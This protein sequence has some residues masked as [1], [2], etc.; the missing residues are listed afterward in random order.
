MALI[1]LS[2]RSIFD[3]KNSLNESMSE[4]YSF[5]CKSADKCEKL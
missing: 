4:K 2:Y 5:L 1:S 3:E